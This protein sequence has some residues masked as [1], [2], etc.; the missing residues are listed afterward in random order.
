MTRMLLGLALLALL[1]GQAFADDR[2][3]Y[4]LFE[5]A[6]GGDELV[7]PNSGRSLN[8]GE[9][10]Q[11]AFGHKFLSDELPQWRADLRFGFKFTL[12]DVGG[13]EGLFYRF[14]LEFTLSRN[15]GERFSVGLGGSFHLFPTYRLDASNVNDEIDFEDAFGW[16]AQAE[17]QTSESFAFGLRY[18]D[19]DY[20]KDG[21]R[22]QLP[23]GNNVSEIDGASTGLYMTYSF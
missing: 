23:N 18:L 10:L 13:G 21:A 15:F 9:L 5:L 6:V 2:R 12:I 3:N 16:V 14:P 4:L 7:D 19:I 17:Y 20:D 22:F 11:V 8:A 1:T